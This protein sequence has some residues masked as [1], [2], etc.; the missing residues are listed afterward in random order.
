MLK[1]FGVVLLCVSACSS[2]HDETTAGHETPHDS[3]T[4]TDSNA[5]ETAS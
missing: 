3:G 4:A 5:E 2:T 1:Y